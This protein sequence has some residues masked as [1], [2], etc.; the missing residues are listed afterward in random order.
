METAGEP[1]SEI[2]LVQRVSAQCGNFDTK[3]YVSIEDDNDANNLT[4][5]T[6]NNKAMDSVNLN[7][8][9]VIESKQTRRPIYIN[10]AQYRNIGNPHCV[11]KEDYNDA[12]NITQQTGTSAV[13]NITNLDHSDIN[14]FDQ[15]QETCTSN[16]NHE[17]QVENCPYEVPVD[18]TNLNRQTSRN[19][20]SRQTLSYI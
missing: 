15:T 6:R 13:I 9:D 3:N 1:S 16:F 17:R 8:D 14:Q 19:S 4:H 11:S 10:T 18:N 5:E 20:V 2:E 7:Y 12:N